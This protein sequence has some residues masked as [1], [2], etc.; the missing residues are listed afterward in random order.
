M[1]TVAGLDSAPAAS[2]SSL[3]DIVTN[4]SGEQHHRLQLHKVAYN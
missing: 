1:V 2:G 3:R 4:R